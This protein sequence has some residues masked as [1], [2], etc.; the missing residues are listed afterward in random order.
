MVTNIMKKIVISAL[1]P[2][3]IEK[4]IHNL[5][6]EE[7]ETIL[8]GGFPYGFCIMNTT[9]RTYINSI[10]TSVR[11]DGG[12]PGSINYHD[13]NINTVTSSRSIYNRFVY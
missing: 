6:K 10:D 7:A 13:N 2:S 5:T 11:Y 12:G 9:D 8:A 1:H 4:L 3:Y